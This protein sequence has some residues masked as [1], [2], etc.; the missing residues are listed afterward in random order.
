MQQTL[1]A[2]QTQS[3]LTAFIEKNQ[4]KSAAEIQLEFGGLLKSLANAA[5]PLPGGDECDQTPQEKRPLE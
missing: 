2:L 4:G 5:P 3:A 1:K